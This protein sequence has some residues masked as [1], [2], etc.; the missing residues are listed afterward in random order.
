MEHIEHTDT[1]EYYQRWTR[2]HWHDNGEDNQI[3]H[4]CM[5]LAGET[6]EVVDLMKKSIFTPH[7]LEGQD[8]RAEVTKE[9]GDVMYYLCRLADELNIDM[10]DVL[11]TNIDKLDERYGK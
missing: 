6:G 2:K 10:C 5:G 9:L 3:L 11:E 4:A 1:L 7:R 8:Y